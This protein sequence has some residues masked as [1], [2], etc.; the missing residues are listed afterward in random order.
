MEDL[1]RALE[2]EGLRESA[3]AMQ[4]AEIDGRIACEWSRVV[5]GVCGAE[6]SHAQ[7]FMPWRCVGL[8][9]MGGS[10]GGRG[11]CGAV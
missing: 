10:D 6:I 8:G 5:F 7:T 9:Q 11:A 1:G 4:K 2:E 3:M